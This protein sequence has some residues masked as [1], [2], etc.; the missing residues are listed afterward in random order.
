MKKTIILTIFLSLL[1]PFAH[2]FDWA[3]WDDAETG[4]MKKGKMLDPLLKGK[5]EV[6]V[7]LPETLSSQRKEYENVVRESIK[8]WASEPAKIIRE[9]KRI[10]EFSDIYSRLSRGVQVVFKPKAPMKV[11]FLDDEKELSD[12]CTE[13]AEGC[14]TEEE[15]TVYMASKRIFAKISH[16]QVGSDEEDYI[17]VLTHEFGHALGLADQ[18]DMLYYENVSWTHSSFDTN[19]KSIMQGGKSDIE[20]DDL[21]G[22][23]YEIDQY[24]IT[25]QSKKRTGWHSFCDKN[26]VYFPNG[27]AGK[28]LA[29]K[30]DINYTEGNSSWLVCEEQIKETYNCKPLILNKNSSFSGWK[31]VVAIPSEFSGGIEQ[32][33]YKFIAVGP[34]KEKVEVYNIF[35]KTYCFAFANGQ[36]VWVDSFKRASKFG[37]KKMGISRNLYFGGKGAVT[38]MHWGFSYNSKSDNKYHLSSFSYK[39]HVSPD[40][41]LNLRAVVLCGF[42]PNKKDNGLCEPSN[43]DFFETENKK[44]VWYDPSVSY[45]PTKTPACVDISCTIQEG[46]KNEIQKEPESMLKSWLLDLANSSAEV[47][48]KFDR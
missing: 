1:F 4:K 30:F 11:V 39:E 32:R 9:Q 47:A 14:Y 45:L 25:P 21:D 35:D 22:L 20:C 31:N 43:T 24:Y 29:L 18:Y 34:N 28:D 2:G 15:H 41:D 5:V 12:I 19:V 33:N 37:D 38:E 8:K 17:S 13:G 26:I 40:K 46:L 36:L 6:T 16:G 27:D 23:I 42:D 10:E 3:G 44:S 48:A 7:K